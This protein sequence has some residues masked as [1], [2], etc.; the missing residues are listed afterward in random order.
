M[1]APVL[2]MPPGADIDQSD[3]EALVNP[4]D[5]TGAQGAGLAK[6]FALRYPLA[7]KA[8]RSECIRPG[9]TPGNVVTCRVKTRH[10]VWRVIVFFPIKR[11]WREPTKLID[12]AA[13]LADLG[14]RLIETDIRS[15][16]IPALGCGLG[17]LAW[18]DVGPLI[19]IFADEMAAND[20]CVE[21]YP[22]HESIQRSRR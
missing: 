17:Q 8:Y 15:V 18:N 11:H 16:A 20:V 5:C 9:V 2:L 22:P 12:I 3:C 21:V 4:V 1:S 14:R 10:D 19:M 6:A 13:G 7:A